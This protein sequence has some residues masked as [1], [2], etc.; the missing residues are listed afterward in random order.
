MTTAKQ[1]TVEFNWTEDFER[2]LTRQLLSYRSVGRQVGPIETQLTY[3]RGCAANF[4][5][6]LR[7]LMDSHKPALAGDSDLDGAIER[8]RSAH[9]GAQHREAL[10]L[11]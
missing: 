8:M 6:R 7:T 11:A 5:Q 10:R 4:I 9:D 2:E 1:K 3:E